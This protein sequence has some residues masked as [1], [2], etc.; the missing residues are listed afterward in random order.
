MTIAEVSERLEEY[1]RR[2]Y[3]DRSGL[4]VSGVEEISQ[5]WETELYSF[6]VEYNEDHRL[7]REDRVARI[8][9]G[10][11]AVRKAAQEFGV[12]SRLLD[13][14]YPVPDVYML[15]TDAGILGKPFVIMERVEGV[16]MDVAIKEGSEK[17]LQ[18]MLG[19]LVVLFVDLHRLDVSLVFPGKE[20]T[21]TLSYIEGMLRWSGER[22]GRSGIGWLDPVISWLDERKANVFLVEPSVIHRDF[23]P[24][25]VMLREDGSPVVIDWGAAAV[26]DYRDDL[27][28]TVLLAVTFWDPSL[29]DT[30]L[31]AYESISGREVRDFEYFEVLSVLRRL[32][33]VA[34]SL[35]SGAEEMGMRAGAEEM[36]RESS[37]HLHKV[38]EILKSRTGL[39]LPEFEELLRTL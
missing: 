1:Y 19:L 10:R 32:T 2:V 7:V 31:G 20:D 16:N 26:G 14:G 12:M 28:W 15:E 30:L 37:D 11:G 39:R 25:N 5:G 35:T 18:Q 3:R 36:M 9:S 6:T 17:N 24:M 4:T 23:H 29:R 13:A 33:D 22:A 27:A 8:Y 38:Y 34:V 21:T